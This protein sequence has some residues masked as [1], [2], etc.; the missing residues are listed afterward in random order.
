MIDMKFYVFLLGWGVWSQ[1]LVILKKKD[2][3]YFLFY[4]I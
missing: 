3:D 1:N 4:Y 2:K